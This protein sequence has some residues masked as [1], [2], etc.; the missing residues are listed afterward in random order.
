MF[1]DDELLMTEKSK[2]LYY[3]GIFDVGFKKTLWSNTNAK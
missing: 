1:V 2:R 3:I